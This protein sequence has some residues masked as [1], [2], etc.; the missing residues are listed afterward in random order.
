[1]KKTRS[2]LYAVLDRKSGGSVPALS[3][4]C[5][6]YV[7]APSRDD[8]GCW[9]QGRSVHATLSVANGLVKAHDE[10]L[11]RL[12]CL[13]RCSF[14]PGAKGFRATTSDSASKCTTWNQPISALALANT[15]AISGSGSFA[16]KLTARTRQSRLFIWSAS[17]TPASESDSGS[18]TSKGYPLMRD[19]TGQN[20]ARLVRA[21]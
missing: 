12:F 9:P 20:K 17:T 1:M 4:L 18:R 15:C 13:E 5:P 7:P 19:V 21:L 10:P 2:R 14:P 6:G 8:P 16:M 11:Y 3:P